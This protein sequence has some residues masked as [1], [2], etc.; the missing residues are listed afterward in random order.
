MSVGDFARL[1]L[2]VHS[3]DRLVGIGLE[4]LQYKSETL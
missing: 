4:Y 3:I 1:L 2:F